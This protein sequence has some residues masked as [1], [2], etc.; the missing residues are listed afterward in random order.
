MMRDVAI[1]L[2]HLIVTVTRLFRPGGARSIAA[3]SLLVKQQLLIVNRSRE[4]APNLRPS[5]RLI[6]GLCASLIR[7]ARLVRTAIILKPTTILSFHRAL[8]KRK[9]RLLFTPKNR[10][11][12]GPKGPSPELIAAI[13]GMKRRNPSFGYQR[14]ADQVSLIFDIKIDKDV[15]RRVLAKHY[16]PAPGSG[17]PSWLT[18]LGHSK[19]SLWSVDLFRCESLILKS[20]WVMVVLDQFSRRIVGFAVHAEVLDGPTVCRMFNSIVGVSTGPQYL[21]SDNDPLFKFHRWKAN[22]RILDVAEVKTVPY[23]PLSH[24]FVERLIG[25]IRRE[26]LD[27]V[28]FWGALDLERKLLLFKQYYNHDRVHRG[29]DGAIPDARPAN[30][31]KKTARLDNYLWKSC[32]RGLYQLPIAA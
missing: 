13:V 4:R 2:I 32:C 19:D 8:V 18:F 3:E 21:S 1:L 9:Y 23:V 22:L 30:S 27:Q 28:P 14:I 16:W 11:K 7:P 6:A 25:T 29:L 12:P 10:G 15:V 20:H 31:G 5:D 24:P 17:G 26:Y